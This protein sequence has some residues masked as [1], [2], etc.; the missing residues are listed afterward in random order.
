MVRFLASRSMS[1]Q[2]RLSSSPR[3]APVYAATWKKANSRC[4][5]AVARNARS[6]ATVQTVSGSWACARGRLDFSPLVVGC[7]PG[8]GFQVRDQA[9]QQVGQVGVA[10]GVRQVPCLAGPGAQCA[11]RGR[12]A[13]VEHGAQRVRSGQDQA[14]AVGA[15]RLPGHRG[16]QGCL[17]GQLGER[18]LQRG[19]DGFQ[20]G[21]SVDLAHAAL[22]LG[23]PR[24]RPADHPGQLG[25]GQASAAPL[26]GDLPPQGLLIV[27]AGHPLVPLPVCRVSQSTSVRISGVTY[28]G[29]LEQVRAVRADLHAVLHGCPRADEVILCASELAANAALH[30]YSRLPGGTFTV[31]ATISPQGYVRIEVQDRGTATPGPGQAQN[32]H[33]PWAVRRAP[34]PVT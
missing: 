25:L 30:S 15:G 1:V 5:L 29:S 4:C 13:A 19:G 9:A 27:R 20:H 22:D 28:P 33:S 7:C 2:R 26:S 31:R 3:R 24:H 14:Q 34:R 23:D 11:D 12:A 8:G 32:H 21:H 17:G 10:P 18:D 6:W 16:D